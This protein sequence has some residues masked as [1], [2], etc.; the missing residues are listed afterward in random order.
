MQT[1]ISDPHSFL[2][3]SG[4]VHDA[5]IQQIVWDAATRFISVSV[6][7]LNAN[8]FGLPEH[9]GPEPGILAFR[10]VEEVSFCCD[11]LAGDIQRVYDL[12]IDASRCTLLISPSGR[13]TFRFASF[14]IFKLS[15]S[16]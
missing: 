6:A 15:G 4:G 5:R 3:E 7:D 16:A 1:L 10:D 12:A 14:E 11:A 2:V 8:A 9:T 13:L